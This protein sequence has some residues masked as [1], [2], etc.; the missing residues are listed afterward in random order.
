M[1]EDFFW[2]LADADFSMQEGMTFGNGYG[3]IVNTLINTCLLYTSGGRAH[4][5]GV[6]GGENACGGLPGI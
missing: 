1:L 4:G 2:V 6:S 5:A 3:A